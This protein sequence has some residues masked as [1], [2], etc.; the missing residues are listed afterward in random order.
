MASRTDTIGAT[1]RPSGRGYMADQQ[2]FLRYA[3]VLAVFI[4]FGFAQFAM[5]GYSNF[6]EAPLTVHLHGGLM[7]AWLGIF[8]AQNMLV[9]K[10]ELAMHRALGWASVAILP[11]LAFTGVLVAYNAIALGRVPP[12]FSAP[13]FLALG[14][15][16]SLSFAAMV[17][18]AVLKR[19]QVQWHRRLMLGAMFL[20]LEPALGRL[21]PM[22]LL[23][24][25]GEWT[26]LLFQLLF[27]AVL[28]RHD[29]KVL[30]AVHPAT[31]ATALV[32]I[33]AHVLFE[34][35][36]VLPPVV[37]FAEAVAAG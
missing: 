20:I 11:V 26:A 21:L 24:A 37:S 7:V 9:H 4:L 30:G 17:V 2:F 1:V 25:W 31:V 6:Q 8:V 16:G 12:F 23:G 35:L 28:A 33:S 5:R 36:A 22:P 27:V 32:L 14:T 15:V 10:G 3:I 13:Y 34:T 29:R 18:W 19:R